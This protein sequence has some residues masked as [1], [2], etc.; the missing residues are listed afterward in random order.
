MANGDGL[1]GGRE[2]GEDLP[3]RLVVGDLAV[4]GQQH[5]RHRGEL[6]GEGGQ[7]VI[8]RGR[9]GNVPLEVGHAVGQAQDHVAVL[10]DEDARTRYSR[11]R[12]VGEE[13]VDGARIPAAE[14]TPP[15][16]AR[17]RGQQSHG[18]DDG[19]DGDRGHRD[20]CVSSPATNGAKYCFH[21]AATVWVPWP[22]VSALVGI[23]T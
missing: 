20:V 11:S 12:V 8:G 6:L 9:G 22:R 3:D 1:G 21:A 7:T 19:T 2:L 16:P 14:R 23:N 18:G 17:A 5:D 15:A 10:Y 4:A 13:R